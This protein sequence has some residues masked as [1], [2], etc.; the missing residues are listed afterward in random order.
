[1]DSQIRKK[2]LICLLILPI[3]ISCSRPDPQP[4]LKDRLFLDMQAALGKAEKELIE[5]KKD[6]DKLRED[7]K[8][9]S[10]SEK[11]LKTINAR[12]I[13]ARDRDIDMLKQKID[14]LRIRANQRA[15]D[16]R[17]DYLKTIEAG[18]EWIPNQSYAD[19][20]AVKR[21]RAAPREWDKRVPK[22]TRYSKRTPTSLSADSKGGEK[23]EAKAAKH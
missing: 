21:I 18:H 4:E 2:M 10:A 19:Y 1:M 3:C 6:L 11:A 7:G 23:K 12:Q 15:V 16:V 14:Y 17:L 8:K 13:R 20:E 22:T 9:I 5:S